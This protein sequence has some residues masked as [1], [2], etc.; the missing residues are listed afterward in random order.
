[1]ALTLAAALF[2]SV[3]YF[4]HNLSYYSRLVGGLRGAVALGLEPTYYWDALDRR[5]LAWLAEHTGDD[6]K[7]TPPRSRRWPTRTAPPRSR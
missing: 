3:T 6:Q 2:D 7:V 1:M 5:T 4:G